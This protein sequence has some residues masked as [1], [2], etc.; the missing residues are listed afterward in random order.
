[1]DKLSHRRAQARIRVLRPDGAPAARTSVR[2]D[3]THGDFLFGCGGFETVELCEC[4]D[5]ARRAF[6][7]DRLEKWLGLFNFA[8]LPFYWG[9]FEPVEGR[10]RTEAVMA[11][12]NWLRERGVTV[13]GHP[14]CWHTSCANWLLKYGDEEILERQLA[15]IRR[16]VTDFKGVIDIWDAINEVVIMP[17]FDKYDNA[18]TRL[19]KAYGRVGLTKR[20]FEAG[21]E[22]NPEALFLINDFNVTPDYEHLLEDLLDAGVPVDAIGIQSHQH[23][24]Y[25][26]L[27]KLQDVLSRFGRFGLPLHFTEN[28]ILSGTLTPPEFDDLNDYAPDPWPSTPEG[29][30][31]QA[32]QIAEMYAALFEHP[33]V[34]AVTYWGISDDGWLGAPGG[35]LGKDNHV[36]P[37][38]EALRGLIHGRW[39]THAELVTDGDGWLTLDGFKGEYAASADAGAARFA[40]HTDE[41]QVLRLN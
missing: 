7:E 9:G 6:L 31:L 29:E 23:Q 28:T 35:L 1:M 40:L 36:K 13:K 16:E 24:G 27:E 15:R 26:G 33:Q 18:V 10:P 30:D 19:C 25:W 38:Y 22:A 3:Q 12:A 4:R 5:E 14:L 21:L 17:V 2:F 34:E 11:G 41:A 39:E 20:V 8:T 37:S 32:Q